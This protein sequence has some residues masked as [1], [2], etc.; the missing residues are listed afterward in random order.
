[1]GNAKYLAIDVETTGL[2]TAFSL[3][4]VS[5]RALDSEF[6]EIKSWFF[7][8]PGPYM[9]NTVALGINNINLI[10]NHK[11]SLPPDQV[12]ALMAEIA[13]EFEVDDEGKTKCYVLG[14]NV[15]FD[16]KFCEKYV[17]GWELLNLSYRARDSKIV[18]QF[19]VDCGLLPGD[20]S[21]SL[22]SVA[23][24]F[25]VTHTPHTAESD[26]YAT[27]EIYKKMM[28]LLKPKDRWTYLTMMGEASK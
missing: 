21:T 24:H 15:Q 3:L 25:G 26:T 2:T 10:D 19:L 12:Y 16:I 13:S 11:A 23:K 6:N 9:V 1:M 8:S 7:C 22:E 27:V 17:P 4:N 5:L 20:L 14:H 18:A 28:D